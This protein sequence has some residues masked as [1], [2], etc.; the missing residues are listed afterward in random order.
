MS[1]TKHACADHFEVVEREREVPIH[2]TTVRITEQVYRCGVCG[3]EE[4][5]YEQ[6]IEAERRAGEVY[7]TEHGFLQPEE[8]AAVR[9]RLGLTQSQLEDAL[10][11][12]RKTVV[13]WE[14]GR[15][16]Q[17]RALDNLLRV[18]D[19]FPDV[20]SFL[21][22]RQG[23]ALPAPAAVEPAPGESIRLPRSLLARLRHQAAEEGVSLDV[24]VAALL[25][26][27][28]ERRAANRALERL[29]SRIEAGDLGEGVWSGGD[30][31]IDAQEP[32][33]REHNKLR[34]QRDEERGLA[35]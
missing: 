17:N 10:G 30:L 2:G 7:R 4:Y 26:E 16:L 35:V 18:I 22:A 21:A 15:V 3:E 8:I 19:A 29:E 13:R 25:A 27:R 6:A 31:T 1:V 9:R 14:A 34:R 5:S 33:L 12:G 23:I 32:W 28:A 20:L 11:I 24:H